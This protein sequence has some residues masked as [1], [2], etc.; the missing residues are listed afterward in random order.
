VIPQT[1]SRVG[2]YGRCFNACIASILEIPEKSVPDFPDED[3]A[4]GPAVQ[5]YLAERGIR[6]SQVPVGEVAPV[7]WHTIEGVSP[8]G[9]MH[10]VVGYNGSMVHDPHPQDGTGRGIEKPMYYGLFLQQE[11][12]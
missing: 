12:E 3:E 9:G 10:A 4:F 2:K 5:K 1:Q 6:Y 11:K 7:G 8:R